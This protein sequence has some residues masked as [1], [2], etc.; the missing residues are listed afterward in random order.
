MSDRALTV[1]GILAITA[2]F[3]AKKDPSCPRLEAE[4]LLGRV[5][6]LKR[7]SLYVNFERLLSEAEI[8]QYRELVRRRAAHEPVAYI[9]G[10]KEFYGLELSVTPDTLIPRPETEHLVDEALRLLKEAA[11]GPAREPD[12]PPGEDPESEDDGEHPKAPA[13]APAREPETVPGQ[14]RPVPE[15]LVADIGTGS[16]AIALALLSSHPSLRVEAT[17]VDPK[18]LAVASLNAKKLGLD[19]RVAFHEGDLAAPLAGKSLD[20]VCANL[21]YVPDRDMDSLAPT[22]ALYEP[23]LAL[24]GGPEGLDLIARLLSSVRPLLREEGFVL[25][26]IWPDSL[27]K[28]QALAA[29]AGLTPMAP[30]LDYSK[31]ARIFVAQA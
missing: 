14:A 1:A 27:A 12:L 10:Q 18:A 16:G 4:L 22:V 6:G 24:R 3:L 25:L 2:D 5:L 26:E 28:V 8:G 30:V 29:Q 9:L 21:P 31:K 11:E 20:L 19:A 7:V 13:P 17:D 15:P 23:P